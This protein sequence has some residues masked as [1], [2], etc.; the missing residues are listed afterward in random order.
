MTETIEFSGM[1]FVLRRDGRYSWIISHHQ[2]GY[3]Y[4]IGS[5]QAPLPDVPGYRGMLF[6]QC[7]TTPRH[8]WGSVQ[9]SGFSSALEWVLVKF[10]SERIVWC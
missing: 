8:K 1:T 6:K 7:E 4:W 9:R 2:T 10:V 5:L 3:A